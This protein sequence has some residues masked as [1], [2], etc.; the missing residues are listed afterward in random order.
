MNV[1]FS[2]I[3]ILI[4]AALAAGCTQR[5]DSQKE[6]AISY[7]NIEKHIAELAS[8]KFLGRT[9]MS[10]AEPL[11]LDYISGQ[12]KEIG[13][14]G[15]NNGSY[16]QDVPIL[17]ITSKLSPT[18]DFETPS[19]KISLNKLTDF[20]A[21][22]Q[23][24]EKEMSLNKSD[25]I[26]AG[27]GI[28]APE[29]GRDDFAGIDVK[30]KTIIVF[31]NDPGYG[32]SGDYFK[33]NTMTYYGRWTYKFE[34]AARQGA[35]ACF[36]VH[37]TGPAGYPWEV[38]RNNGETTR[39]FLEPKDG[40]KNR[41]SFEGWITK[42][43][44]EKIFQTCGYSF[45]EMK[46]K[47]INKNF[48]SFELPLIASVSI[49]STFEHGISKNVCGLIKGTTRPDEVVLYTAH[50]DH[51]GVGTPL[52][53][54]SIYNGATDNASAVAW[55]LEIARAF[56]N[57]KQPER[58]VLFL[59]V[60]SEESGLLGSGYYAENPFFPMN[61]TVACINT[62]INL[63][64]GKFKDVTITGFGQSELDNWL[65]V[66]AE[67]QGRYLAADPNPENGMYFR[68]DHFPLVKKGVPAIFA[69]GY[70]EAEKYGK[71]KTSQFISDYWKNKYHKPTDEY[72]PETDDLN[73]L[74]Q[75]AELFY[76]VGFDLAN[77]TEWP[78]WNNDSEFKSVRESSIN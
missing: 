2:K 40:Y 45:D 11:V 13:L 10:P 63:F 74:V 70:I 43:S 76:K 68:S 4:F 17:G 34:E 78:R 55:M 61:K 33:G 69:K 27:F 49:K 64:I 41:C 72:H 22:S 52:N 6:S 3:F 26:F 16:F 19:G 62:D 66:E 38:V 9:P 47:A 75:D 12:M 50:W 8:D 48:K 46:Q 35:K 42:D 73:G 44:A 31:V 28:S 58:S 39:L 21:F 60:T 20:V 25:V 57:G 77:S 18:L 56:T 1:N 37:E 59:S 30:G 54:D 15:A 71:E 7:D 29:Y 53:G 24:V 67:K 36:I 65:K 51:L 23:K 32:T 5:R 14:E